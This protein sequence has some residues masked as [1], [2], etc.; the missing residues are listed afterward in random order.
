MFMVWLG[1]LLMM[2]LFVAFTVKAPL[3]LS[4]AVAVVVAVGLRT[5]VVFGETG[6]RIDNV[7]RS[8][9]FDYDEV[10]AFYTGW[11][12]VWLRT[13]DLR[14]IW[15]AAFVVLPWSN[16]LADRANAELRRRR[17]GVLFRP[18]RFLE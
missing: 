2:A 16:D 3:F 14:D 10:Q 6:I 13:N 11:N 15:C 1:V 9:R 17:P 8:H 12:Y 7:F 5:R 4:L 18:V